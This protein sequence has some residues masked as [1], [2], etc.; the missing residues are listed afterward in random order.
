MW[1]SMMSRSGTGAAALEDAHKAAPDV[2]QQSMP[3]PSRIYSYKSK[4]VQAIAQTK[5]KI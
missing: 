2:I 5:A 4:L 1:I 3:S